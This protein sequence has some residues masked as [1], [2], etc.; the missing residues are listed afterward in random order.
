M[1]GGVG[2]NVGKC[3]GV[4]VCDDVGSAVGNAGKWGCYACLH[5]CFR[6]NSVRLRSRRICGRHSGNVLLRVLE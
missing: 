3:F 4:E 6:I 2:R 5:V 1:L